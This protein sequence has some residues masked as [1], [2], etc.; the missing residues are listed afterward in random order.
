M[1]ESRGTVEGVEGRIGRA[2]DLRQMHGSVSAGGAGPAAVILPEGQVVG[3]GEKHRL[4]NAEFG[5]QVA[6]LAAGHGSTVNLR[7]GE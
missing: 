1:Q 5:R 3:D 2:G 4:R 7:R 6:Q